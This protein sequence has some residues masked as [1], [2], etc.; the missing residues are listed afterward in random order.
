MAELMEPKNLRCYR[1]ITVLEYYGI[2]C[3]KLF[4]GESIT[5]LLGSNG[6]GKTS[7]LVAVPFVLLPDLRRNS[8]EGKFNFKPSLKDPESDP[9]RENT[10]LCL[11][12]VDPRGNRYVF[13]VKFRKADG[14]L[15]PET[16]IY[17]DLPEDLD[18]VDLI[19]LKTDD[20]RLKPLSFLEMRTV[21]AGAGASFKSNLS[22]K[23]YNRTLSNACLAPFLNSQTKATQYCEMISASIKG[24]PKLVT[25][26]LSKFMIGD[27]GSSSS[28]S[29]AVEQALKELRHKQRQLSEYS[30]QYLVFKTLA[31]LGERNLVVALAMVGLS[32]AGLEAS[33]KAVNKNL[34]EL[35]EQI[36]ALSTAISDNGK[37]CSDLDKEKDDLSDKRASADKIR[38]HTYQLADKHK[39]Q[40]EQ[41]STMNKLENKRKEHR[42]QYRQVKNAAGLAE[43]TQK[44][45]TQRERELTNQLSSQKRLLDAAAQKAVQYENV[46]N[47]KEA[48]EE[49]TGEISK[50]DIPDFKIQAYT[51]FS[52]LG[53][54]ESSLASQIQNVKEIKQAYQQTELEFE[55]AGKYS[56]PD[57]KS[58]YFGFINELLQTL[59]SDVD[60]L[61]RKAEAEAT[62]ANV[63]NAIGHKSVLQ[64]AFTG[65]T[66]VKTYDDFI[67]LLDKNQ[68]TCTSLTQAVEG[69]VVSVATLNTKKAEL[70][71]AIERAQDERTQYRR[72]V[73]PAINTFNADDSYN[74]NAKLNVDILNSG[75]VSSLQ[76]KKEL[77]TERDELNYQLRTEKQRK[78][79]VS[80]N[81]GD[82]QMFQERIAS[83]VNGKTLDEVLDPDI[84]A[85]AYDESE[86]GHLRNAIVVE[87]VRAA[88]ADVIDGYGKVERLRHQIC[89]IE[90]S[91]DGSGHFEL[92]FGQ[93]FTT[94]NLSELTGSEE[95]DE[96][97]PPYTIVADN[98]STLRLTPIPEEPVFGRRARAEAKKACEERIIEIEVNLDKCNEQRRENKKLLDA[99]ETL[100]RNIELAISG[101]PDVEALQSKLTNVEQDCL[102]TEEKTDM[103]R[104]KLKAVS[105][106]KNRLES[107]ARY[108]PLLDRDLDKEEAAVKKLL[109]QVVEAEYRN[110]L[111]RHRIESIESYIQRLTQPYP[112]DLDKL[113]S[114]LNKVKEDRST[115]YLLHDNL[116]LL[117]RN[118]HHLEYEEYAQK[119]ITLDQT[120]TNLKQE[121]QR[122]QNE[123]DEARD[124]LSESRRVLEF[125]AGEGNKLAGQIEEVTK[126]LNELANFFADPENHYSEGD[127]KKA[128][129]NY[130][131]L[132]EAFGSI[133]HNI[134][135]LNAA[136]EK[137]R[138]Q[139]S[140]NKDK[141]LSEEKERTK[142][143]E[144]LDGMTS[145]LA[146]SYEKLEA[147]DLT[148]SKRIRARV[149]ECQ[150]NADN[151]SAN[152]PKCG[153][154]LVRAISDMIKLPQML[155][156]DTEPLLLFNVEG[157]VLHHTSIWLELRGQILSTIDK[158]ISPSESL[159]RILT[160]LSEHVDDL[161]K[162]CDEHI[163]Q[164][165]IESNQI[166]ST[167]QNKLNTER[168][169]IKK[170]SALLAGFSF[171]QIGKIGLKYEPKKEYMA[172]L[173]T[174]KGIAV[175][176]GTRSADMFAEE[177]GTIEELLAN[178]WKKANRSEMGN[179]SK[180]LDHNNYFRVK[181]QF[182]RVSAPGVPVGFEG[183]LSTGESMGMTLTILT[184]LMRRI[185]PGEEGI[186]PILLPMDELARMDEKARAEVLGVA[187]KLKIQI[188][189]AHPK[190]EG[191]DMYHDN[192]YHQ[193]QR[194]TTN[195]HGRNLERVIIQG[196]TKKRDEV[197]V[198]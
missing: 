140:E 195:L 170:M 18:P 168:R 71:F 160:D 78:K 165:K 119:Q 145:N 181:I 87:D 143:V 36:E 130:L 153:S 141:A 91:R 124:K 154:D 174:L 74:I 150:E 187:R 33:L 127:E 99:V 100:S 120:L 144:R 15:K 62:K 85:A 76:R 28:S 10:V 73:L 126:L 134:Q 69:F 113:G 38:R 34:E 166:V 59:R 121:I 60:L 53:G 117:E 112:E 11:E 14:K 80:D 77:K 184:V 88:A 132:D 147:V 107:V 43:E 52:K 128:E 24:D 42:E 65:E 30:E 23:E 54:E 129:E 81:F 61:E 171:G 68:K 49:K 4:L 137:Q 173:E 169:Q 110:K 185:T 16:F 58:D 44:G 27:K 66:H 149:H 105:E 176:D 51:E 196:L 192:I 178:V 151:D 186:Q 162:Q 190:Y 75:R 193:L 159:E 157:D 103:L 118:F 133:K 70:T 180:L 101:D 37:K 32:T 156:R 94:I 1:S 12:A 86:Y 82:E 63:T 96:L 21:A 139:L 79:T 41:F 102:A 31:E 46:V 163:E 194:R 93:H 17:S 197:P 155:G 56:L 26:N 7:L 146:R 148:E 95:D 6:A 191:E 55:G 172:V 29:R 177:T 22:L 108:A 35:G 188:L 135:K 131:K 158:S 3:K 2:P 50:G 90:A 175:A 182:E 116:Q 25:E 198:N 161:H 39:T 179:A 13:G 47:L 20:G 92:E 104:V 142:L 40:A 83:L 48:L 19:T 106:T 125:I 9:I 189:A 138:N 57:S 45:L 5:A 123:S 111:V 98:Q 89:F 183:N 64:K 84:E 164:F 72:D 67:Q 115:A 167:I 97:A 152:L 8:F 122:V 109:G 136:L 114:L